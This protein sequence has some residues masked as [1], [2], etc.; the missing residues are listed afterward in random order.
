MLNFDEIVERMAA[1][2]KEKADL[3]APPKS[4]RNKGLGSKSSV[5]VAPPKQ[6]LLD[7]G[8]E[9]QRKVGGV[10]M[11]VLENGMPY[12]TQSGLAAM[13]GT[14]RR[15]I[16]QLSKEWE[17]AF[18]D[19]IPKRGR[20]AF[21]KEYLFKNGYDEPRLYLKIPKDNSVHYAYPDIV[22]MAVIEFFAFESQD[23]NDTAQ[24][25]YRNLA[26]YGLQ[27]FIYTALK[28]APEDKWRHFWD[29]VSILN[30]RVPPGYF[31]VF[32]EV[33][34]LVIDLIHAGLTVND[35]TIPD[36]SVGTCWGNFWTANDLDARVGGRMQWEHYY[37]DYYP[38]A[39]SNPQLAWAYPDEALPI[40]RQ[41]FRVE[42]LTT[43]F[44]SY[45]LKKADAL[46]GG[47]KEA[48]RIARLYDHEDS[49][50]QLP[51]P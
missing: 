48:K 46:L 1:V 9:V 13:S 3:V 47:A 42:Y 4:I 27:K 14:A 19:P 25:N 5:L 41:W 30:D 44:P 17:E 29:R 21:I 33:N 31:I 8:I 51:P 36:V 49:A 26:R 20:M 18:H 34:G 50:K 11:G 32:R 16:Q 22:C 45:I 12:L 35:K 7:L 15:S 39:K 23:R 43:K 37:P 38:Q 28:Y 40:F 10:E 24:R 6:L 2:K